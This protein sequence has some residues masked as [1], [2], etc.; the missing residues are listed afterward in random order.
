MLFSSRNIITMIKSRNMRWAS[1]VARMGEMINA[2]SILVGKPEGKNHSEKLGVDGRII[3]EWMLGKYGGSVWKMEAAWS[4]E[5]FVSNHST[6]KMK[7]AWSSET[8]VSYHNTTHHHNPED[9]DLNLHRV[10]TTSLTRGVVLEVIRQV[11]FL[12]NL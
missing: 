11:F 9:V 4:P 12:E 3:L 1:L 8:L 6:L 5:T 7:A 2:Y 10:I